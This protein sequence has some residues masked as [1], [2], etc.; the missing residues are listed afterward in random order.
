MDN[1][2]GNAP[3]PSERDKIIF[4]LRCLGKMCALVLYMVSVVSQLRGGPLMQ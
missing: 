3:D 2:K 1:I 4:V